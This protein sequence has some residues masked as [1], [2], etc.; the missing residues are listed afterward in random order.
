VASH[1]P[2]HGRR[3]GG[4]GGR[5]SACNGLL[6]FL[7]VL[8]DAINMVEPFTHE[9]I[10]LPLPPESKTWHK[11]S[12]YC[13]GFDPRPREQKQLT[14]FFFVLGCL[15]ARVCLMSNGLYNMEFIG[16]GA[17]WANSRIV[18]Q[19]PRRYL[20]WPQPVHRGHLLRRDYENGGLYAS[21]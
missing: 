16:E 1:S 21:Y 6:C 13:F 7:D 20:T 18:R 14:Q 8:R 17:R 2:V 5:L 15:D 10:A 19:P 9:S 12:A 11:H 3:V 4:H